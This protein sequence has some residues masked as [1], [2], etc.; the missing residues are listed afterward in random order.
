VAD[1]G[2]RGGPL[3]DGFVRDLLAAHGLP[4]GTPERLQGWSNQVWVA[5]THVVRVSSGRF[6]GSF[7]YEAR[8]LQAL[9]HVPCPRVVATARAGGQ[10]WMIET[11]LAGAS[12]LK[13]WP[14]LEAPEREAAIR[15]LACA[16]R[17]VHGTPARGDLA[18]PP[19]RAAAL[20]PGGDTSM[21]Y[22]AP[23]AAY[24]RLVEANLRLGAAPESLLR[25]A[26]RFIE[27]RLALFEGDQPVLTHGDVS[28]AN[29]LWD[30]ERA[31]LVDFESC[32]LAPL[33]RELDMLLRCLGAPGEFSPD[34]STSAAPMFSPAL[35][36]LRDA[37]PEL[38]S[39][40][41][42]IA[43]LEVYDVL[44]ELVQLLNYPPDHP[45]NSAAR[46]A[47]ILA[48]DAV[49]KPAIAALA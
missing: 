12:L 7:E 48:G 3:P 25:D 22:R 1:R 2:R 41:D 31:A 11:R 38:F 26:G 9:Q 35:G 21:A 28:F 47:R 24:P 45:R 14:S 44:W 40:P 19:W 23:P 4:C 27:L 20:A 29:V 49:W 39:H 5:E 34:A 8:V 36:W 15:S 13:A 42:L 16:L 32:A 43:R 46:L 33:D 17:A 10:E 18:E 30:G 6:A 37:C